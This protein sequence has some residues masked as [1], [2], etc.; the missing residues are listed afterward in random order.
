MYGNGTVAGMLPATGISIAVGEHNV[1]LGTM[2]GVAVGA[3]VVGC[4]IYRWASRP[5]RINA[6]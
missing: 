3:V 2:I 5:K 4:A 1:V 6:S